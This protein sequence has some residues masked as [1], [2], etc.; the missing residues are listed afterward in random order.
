MTS[1][2]APRGPHAYVYRSTGSIIAIAGV[3]V[4]ALFFIVDAV[5]RAGLYSGFLLTP[6]ALGLVWIVYVVS[7]SSQLI[8]DDE[9]VT[10]QNYL[11]RTRM[12]WDQIADLSVRWQIE[13]TLRDGHSVKAIGGPSGVA[14]RRAPRVPDKQPRADV[15]FVDRLKEAQEW[16]RGAGQVTRTIDTAAIIAL[17]IILLWIAVAVALTR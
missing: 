12:P 13:F 6:W 8:F 14:V 16:R 7:F 5:M 4:L 2:S 11:L 15:E 10:V 3:S 17:G 1:F 9:G